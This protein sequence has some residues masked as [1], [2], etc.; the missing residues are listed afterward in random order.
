VPDFLCGGEA[1][2]A[3]T[4]TPDA[5]PSVHLPGILWIDCLLGDKIPP[6]AEEGIRLNVQGLIN[7]NKTSPHSGFTVFIPV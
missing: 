6:S 4:L 1:K 2:L 3:V 5:D 7:F